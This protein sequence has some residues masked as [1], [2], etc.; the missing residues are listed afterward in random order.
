MKIL[1]AY[2]SRA[3]KTTFVQ[4][5]SLAGLQ[6]QIV[7][8]YAGGNNA[9]KEFLK[10]LRTSKTWL[11]KALNYRVEFLDESVKADLA[12][13]VARLDLIFVPNDKAKKEY[14]QLKEIQSYVHMP[15]EDFEDWYCEVIEHTCK[16]CTRDDYKACAMRRVMAKHRVFPANP[17]AVGTCQYSYVGADPAELPAPRP[18]RELVEEVV[19]E[20]EDAG[21]S[22]GEKYAAETENADADVSHEQ[23]SNAGSKCQHEAP[24]QQVAAVVPVEIYLAGGKRL[25]LEL[26]RR[27]AE[28]LLA[29]MKALPKYSRPVCACHVGNELVAVDTQELAVFRAHGIGECELQSQGNMNAFSSRNASAGNQNAMPKAL[30]TATYK[31][32]CK[33]GAE[34]ICRLAADRYKARC[35]KCHEA[36]YRDDQA[37]EPLADGGEAAL[38][39]NRY[40]VPLG[41]ARAD[42]RGDGTDTQKIMNE[43]CR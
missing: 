4:L 3:E 39:T 24:Q 41:Q 40:F 5:T 13:Q 16:T 1:N 28:Q 17:A 23:D 22:S 37:V 21:I 35:Q 26:P 10:L 36:V 43:R 20:R 7:E 25:A 27:M 12:R 38:M 42:Q 8:M 18:P 29:G 2:L 14:E 19:A 6:E 34:Y 30:G 15:M 33:C 32:E 11:M 9:D 31:V